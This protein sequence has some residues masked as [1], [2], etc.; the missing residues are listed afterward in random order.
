[1]E[2][3]VQIGMAKHVTSYMRDRSTAGLFGLAPDRVDWEARV[4]YESKGTAGAVEAVS[5][6]T[7]FFALMLSIA[8]GEQW[9]AV[10]SILSNR[11]QREVALT[12]ERME[13][14]WQASERLEALAVQDPCRLA[15]A[16]HCAKPVRWR[17]FAAMLEDVGHG[18]SVRFSRSALRQRENTLTITR[19]Q[20]P[21]VS[22]ERIQHVVLLAEKRFKFPV[23]DLVCKHG[24][25]LSIFDYYGYYKG[26]FELSIR[27]L[28]ADQ[29][30][31]A[32]TLLDDSERQALLGKSCVGRRIICAPIY[33]IIATGDMALEPALQEM[34]HLQDKIN[35][36]SDVSTL[37]GIEGNLHQIYY[38]A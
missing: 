6:Q 10:T 11:K 23:A 3:Q 2:C 13:R 29:T 32:R 25:R 14:L 8:S 9:R 4:V 33:C 7:A 18:N 28:W 37:M 5:D 17:C 19:W 22:I 21:R 30:D 24:V 26:S 27:I 38:A 12:P 31:S 1:M 16:F 20:N 36:A 35:K 15:H 34:A